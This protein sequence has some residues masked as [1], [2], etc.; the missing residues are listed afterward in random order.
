MTSF[1][2]K[3]NKKLFTNFLS[4]NINILPLLT[5]TKDEYARVFVHRKPLMSS[6]IAAGKVMSSTR[7]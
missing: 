7:I 6:L 5:D 1:E 4:F 3:I 2:E